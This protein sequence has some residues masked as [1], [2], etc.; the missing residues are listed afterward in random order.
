MVSEFKM[1]TNKLTRLRSCVHC[2]DM[3]RV[4]RNYVVGLVVEESSMVGIVSIWGK[5]CWDGVRI[6]WMVYYLKWKVSDNVEF[7]SGGFLISWYGFD[8]ILIVMKIY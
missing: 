2:V 6:C 3:Y 5:I 1:E 8:G 7:I 4:F